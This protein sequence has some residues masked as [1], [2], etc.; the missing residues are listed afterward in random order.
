MKYLTMLFLLCLSG[1]TTLSENVQLV[2]ANTEPAHIIIYRTS[3]FQAGAVSMYLGENDQYFIKLRND[4][5]ASVTLDSG[6]HVFQAKADASPSSELAI[7]LK[8]HT[9]TCLMVEPNPDMLGA[10]MVPLIA[11]MVPTFV[12]KN[13]ACPNDE[14]LNDYQQVYNS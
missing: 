10:V 13:I 9:K 5:Y 7:T 14:F 4:Q 12:L 6:K 8:P 3:A 11:N 2:S 1:C